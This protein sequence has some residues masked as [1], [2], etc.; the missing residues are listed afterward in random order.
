M[1]FGADAKSEECSPNCVHCRIN[2]FISTPFAEGGL[3]LN[4]L[5]DDDDRYSEVEAALMSVLAVMAANYKDHNTSY[6]RVAV[7]KEM[8]DDLRADFAREEAESEQMEGAKH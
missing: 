7:F 1:K 4:D 5:A 2:S 8:I 6:R 3:G